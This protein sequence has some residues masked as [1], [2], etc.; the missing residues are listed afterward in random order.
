MPKIINEKEFPINVN[1]TKTG[2]NYAGKFKAK[3]F[4]SHLDDLTMDNLRRQFLGPAPGT[5]YPRIESQAE[6]LAETAVCLIEAPNWWKE[7]DNGASLLD[8]E[9][10]QEVVNECRRIR[11]EALKAVKDAAKPAKEELAKQDFD[12]AV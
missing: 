10:L 7:A 8:D 9:P 5:P 3:K 1:G 4:L 6:A 2:E 12:A 11:E